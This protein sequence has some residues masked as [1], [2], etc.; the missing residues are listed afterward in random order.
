MA[1]QPET[2]VVQ[3][4]LQ[5]LL[6]DVLAANARL[7]RENAQMYELL[8]LIMNAWPMDVTT[9]KERTRTFLAQYQEEGDGDIAAGA[10]HAW[11]L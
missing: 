7:R 10:M 4:L 11:L 2:E 3:E 5:T 9:A 6:R 1:N 8:R